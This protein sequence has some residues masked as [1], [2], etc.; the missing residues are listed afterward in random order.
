[1]T[2]FRVCTVTDRMVRQVSMGPAV[3][4]NHCVGWS[5]TV[6]YVEIGEGGS[7]FRDDLQCFD[8]LKLARSER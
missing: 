4:S 6:I 2:F 1:M 5:C 7:E 8:E 3:M